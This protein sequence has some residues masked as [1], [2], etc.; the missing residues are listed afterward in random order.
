MVT[1]KIEVSGVTIV[2]EPSPV[3]VTVSAQTPAVNVQ[4]AQVS[5]SPQISVQPASV[6]P[7]VTVLPAPVPVTVNIDLTPVMHMLSGVSVML[8]RIA[9][10]N[11]ELVKYRK[12]DINRKSFS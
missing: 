9:D 6:Q 11:D 3:P 2:V 5:V 1:P 10:S 4:P 7:Q 8:Q 12:M